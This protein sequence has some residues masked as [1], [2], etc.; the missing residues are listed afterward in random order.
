[1]TTAYH[2]HHAYHWWP[3]HRRFVRFSTRGRRLKQLATVFM[4]VS[5]PAILS[6]ANT[7]SGQTRYD[8]L[9]KGGHVIDGK[10]NI[11]AIR[12]LAITGGKISALAP[13]IDPSL[14]RKVVDV[15]GLW[16]TPGLIDIHEHVYTYVAQQ[17]SQADD[18][19]FTP[20][21][22]AFRAGVTTVVDAGSSGWRTFEDFKTRVI[23]RSRT[24]VLALLNI[25]GWGKRGDKYV[26]DL[27]DMDAKPTSEMALKHKGVVVGIKCADFKGPEWKSYEQA[28]EAGR[29][30]DVPVMIDFGANRTERPLYDLLTRVLR[31]GDIYTHVYWG[32]MGE[33][34][35]QTGGPSKALIE[36]RKRGVIFDVG[37]GNGVF[38]FSLAVPLMKV[39]FVPDSF[40]TDV[41]LNSSTNMNVAMNDILEVMSEFLAMGMPLDSAIM[42]ATWNPAKEIKHQELG[43][44]SAGSPADVAV[45]RLENGKFSFVDRR[46]ASLDGTRKLI[47]ELTIRDGKVVYDRNG[48]AR[49]R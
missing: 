16:V 28:V 3:R 19:G 7:L 41:H 8:L 35:E 12:D 43:N 2:P 47:C 26:Q 39:G 17:S 36:G 1:M 33:Q 48:I 38:A 10:N 13:N 23:D 14:A 27:D 37:H 20:D 24:R 9:L 21:G 25:V 46:R 40:S 49:E 30:A 6:V 34:D 45:L 22:F 4:A 42:R 18:Q 11:N 31:P 32:L 5:L 15:S 29:I 44:L